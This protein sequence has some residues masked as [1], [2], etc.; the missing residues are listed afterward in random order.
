MELILVRH[1]RPDMPQGICYGRLDVGV[2]DTFANEAAEV[3][4]ALPEVRRLISSPLRRCRKLARR[5]ATA[6]E[7]PLDFDERLAEMDFGAWEGRPWATLPASELDAWAADFMHARPHG[8]ES[9]AM[10]QA[11]V[12]AALSHW[13]A[14]RSARTVPI[15]FI[16]HAGVI[17][18]AC[19][20]AG[21][22]ARDFSIS[23][24]FGGIMALT[25][26]NEAF[27]GSPNHD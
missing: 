19:S 25:D 12:R 21:R 27:A 24:A 1:T 5:I 11:R 13:S 4:D 22:T 23:V 20:G 26:A 6:R 8:G 15:A 9:V 18:A 16:T 3:L 2:R 14:Q 10:L 7:L 17:K